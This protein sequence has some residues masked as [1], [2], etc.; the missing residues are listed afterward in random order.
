VNPTTQY[1]AWYG[2]TASRDRLIQQCS[3]DLA[4]LFVIYLFTVLQSRPE[5]PRPKPR[6]ASISTCSGGG[7]GRSYQG[8]SQ[9]DTSTK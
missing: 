3:V 1:V 6:P 5:V 2:L 7:N 4:M 8:H 9:T